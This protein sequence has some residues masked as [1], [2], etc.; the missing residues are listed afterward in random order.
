MLLVSNAM[1][2]ARIALE[3]PQHALLA[4][5]ILTCIKASAIQ[6]AHMKHTLMPQARLAS[7]ATTTVLYAVLPRPIA[8][9]AIGQ[10]HIFPT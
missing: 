10:H 4:T 3:T 8:R 1:L 9:F 5:Q 7:H 2:T 6:P